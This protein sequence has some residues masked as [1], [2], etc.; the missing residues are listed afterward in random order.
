MRRK[1]EEA[2]KAQSSANSTDIHSKIA[3]S[4]I[5][6]LYLIERALWDKDQPITRI[7]EC[8]ACASLDDRGR[9][10]G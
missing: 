9:Q 8:R 6:E 1:F 4:Y 3:P 2:R 10:L 5:R 7:I